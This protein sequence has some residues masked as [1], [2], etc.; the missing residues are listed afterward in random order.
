ML[1]VLANSGTLNFAEAIVQ[2]ELWNG[3]CQRQIFLY[4][5]PAGGKVCELVY[6]KFRAS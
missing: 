3:V 2:K 6:A 5:P 1:A 4:A